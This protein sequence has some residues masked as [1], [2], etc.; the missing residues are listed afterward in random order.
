MPKNKPITDEK[1]VVNK[2]VVMLTEGVK[3]NMGL[4]VDTILATRKAPPI[5]LIMPINPPIMVIMADSERNWSM[6]ERVLAPKAL[7]MPISLVRSVTD[8]SMI[9]ITPIPPTIS[10]IAATSEIN[11]V[12]TLITVL[13]VVM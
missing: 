6:M 4:R 2:M 12:T 11:M 5:P 9:F 8:T 1:R 7:R 13:T 10:E 3:E